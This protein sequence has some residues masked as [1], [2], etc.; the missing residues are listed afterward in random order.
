MQYTKALKLFKD[1]QC[2]RN[3][4]KVNK[5]PLC[6]TGQISRQCCNIAP[7]LMNG[8]YKCVRRTQ[9]MGNGL[10]Y[11]RTYIFDH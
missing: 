7:D 2:F 6:S 10:D 5:K 1:V 3:V 4:V 11:L 8:I 9:Y